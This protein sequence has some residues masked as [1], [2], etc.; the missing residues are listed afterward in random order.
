MPYNPEPSRE[1]IDKGPDQRWN[2]IRYM[3][4]ASYGGTAFQLVRMAGP[5]RVI[6]AENTF[7]GMPPLMTIAIRGDRLLRLE[8]ALRT[9]WDE[10][11]EVFLEAVPDGNKKRLNLR[12]VKV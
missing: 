12:G 1:W 8:Q 6:V 7:D 3:T 5:S 4:H 11:I 9:V 2:I 10:S